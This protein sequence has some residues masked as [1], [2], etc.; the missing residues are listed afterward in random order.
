MYLLKYQ[1]CTG[2][3][4]LYSNAHAPID[5]QHAVLSQFSHKPSETP[6]IISKRNPYFDVS[7]N[8]TQVYAQP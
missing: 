6:H 4:I 7:L 1:S 5:I 2:S 3:I 8:L